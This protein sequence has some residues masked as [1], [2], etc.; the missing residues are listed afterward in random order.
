MPL[1]G[2]TR[3]LLSN[4]MFTLLTF[5]SYFPAVYHHA[6]TLLP[7]GH[8]RNSHFAGALDVRQPH[9]AHDPP[10]HAPPD[11]DVGVP[12]IDRLPPLDTGERKYQTVECAFN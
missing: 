12:A 3:S 1:K 2:R 5:T 6:D 4:A 9:P 8:L 11:H 7:A 10:H